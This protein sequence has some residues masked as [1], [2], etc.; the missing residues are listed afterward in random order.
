MAKDKKDYKGYGGSIP[1][2]AGFLSSNGILAPKN[3]LPLEEYRSCQFDLGAT[4]PH[5]ANQDVTH[6]KSYNTLSNGFK[7]VFDKV[8][9]KLYIER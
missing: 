9:I 1:A 8:W 5:W 7:K 3:I 2:K 6:D 4:K